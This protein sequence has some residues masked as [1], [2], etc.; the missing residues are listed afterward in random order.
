MTVQEISQ[1]H[2]RFLHL[3]AQGLLR[4]PQGKPEKTHVL[5]C[6]RQMGVLQIDTINVVARSPYLV[7]WSRLG[8]YKPN[9]LNELL[10]ETKLFEYWAHEASFLPIEEFAH[11]R[12]QM[13]DPAHL[14]WRF[15]HRWLSEQSENIRQVLEKISETGPMRSKDFEHRR[16][17]TSGWWDWKPEKKSLEVLLTTG[18]LMIRERDQFQRVYDLTSRVLP[19]WR[20]TDN[21]YSPKDSEKHLLHKAI[22]ALGIAC[23]EWIPDYF[24]MR[25]KHVNLE[26]FLEEQVSSGNLLAVKIED[27]TRRFFV[28]Q[29]F[30]SLLINPP[31]LSSTM[32]GTRILSP[33]DPVV[34]DRRRAKELFSFDYR[35]ECYTPEHKRRYGYFCLPVLRNGQ[36]VA[37]LD[38]KAHRQQ[39]IF[40][41][42]SLHPEQSIRQSASLFAD[43]HKKLTEMASWHGCESIRY[44]AGIPSEYRLTHEC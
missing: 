17:S 32:K 14:G 6:I 31:A 30:A 24:R 11:F 13:L 7:L 2:A 38:A 20:D 16:N 33:F 39:K 23:A 41:I 35:L 19:D 29:Q 18:Q 44:G 15:N 1:K 5:A 40:E 25:L 26:N 21:P 22:E 43:V 12:H 36:F 37:R 4:Y 8:N 42:K 28:H 9:F 34:W 27:D 10:A 3:N